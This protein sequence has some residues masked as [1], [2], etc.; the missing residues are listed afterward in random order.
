MQNILRP[1]SKKNITTA[2]KKFHNQHIF[3]YI[4]P[5]NLYFIVLIQ[6]YRQ[7]KPT[8]SISIIKIYSFSITIKKHIKA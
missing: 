5:L 6:T 8:A 2:Y 1:T 3:L 4:K 7:Q